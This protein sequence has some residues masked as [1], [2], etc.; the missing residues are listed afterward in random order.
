MC[1]KIQN[2]KGLSHKQR[3]QAYVRNKVIFHFMFHFYARYIAEIAEKCGV[4]TIEI[5]AQ[6]CLAHTACVCKE[7]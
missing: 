6:S 2:I 7:L 5:S 4:L 1:F 3:K